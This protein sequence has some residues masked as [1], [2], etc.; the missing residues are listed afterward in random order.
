MN[1]VKKDTAEDLIE[2]YLLFARYRIMKQIEGAALHDGLNYLDPALLGSDEAGRL[3]KA[4]RTVET[5]QKYLQQ[6]ILFGQSL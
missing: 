1:M 4:M 3:R 5:F 6:V 2:A